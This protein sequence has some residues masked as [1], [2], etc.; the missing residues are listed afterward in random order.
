[1]ILALTLAGLPVSLPCAAQRDDEDRAVLSGH[2]WFDHIRKPV[3]L[4]QEQGH[5]LARRVFTALQTSRMRRDFVP[6]G[7][8]DYAPRLVFLSWRSRDG[9]LETRLGR[10]EGLAKAFRDVLRSVTK[11]RKH[12]PDKNLTA[13][14]I[15]IVQQSFVVSTF[16]VDTS[17]IVFPSVTGLAFSETSGFAFLP[18]ELVFNGFFQKQLLQPQLIAQRL[19]HREQW[20]DFG[21]WTRISSYRRPQ[22]VYLFETQAFYADANR[23]DTL[24]NG[25][26]LRE[27]VRATELLPAARGAGDFLCRAVETSGRITFPPMPWEVQ[28]EELGPANDGTSAPPS[29]PPARPPDMPVPERIAAALALLQLHH[30]T[31]TPVFAEK[32]EALLDPLVRTLVLYDR[33]GQALCL[34][35]ANGSGLGV[36]ALLAAVLATHAKTTGHDE[37]TEQIERIGRHLLLQMQP[38]GQFSATCILPS[39]APRPEPALPAAAFRAV[40]ALV[41]LYETTGNRSFVA[42][43]RRGTAFLI[44]RCIGPRIPIEKLPRDEWSVMALNRLY[45]YERHDTIVA[46]VERLALAIMAD[47]TLDS[48]LPD[49]VGSWREYPSAAAAA[50]MSQ[51]LAA[52][53]ELLH[54]TGREKAARRIAETVHAYLLFQMQTRYGDIE[55]F[56]L[57]RAQPFAGGFRNDCLGFA[58]SVGGQAEQILSLLAA[59]RLFEALK[60]DDELP[61]SARQ[62]E[63]L[64]HAR[65]MAMTFPR[66]LGRQ[67]TSPTDGTDRPPLTVQ[68]VPRVP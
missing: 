15:D 47:Q 52:A 16:N 56:Y 58:F 17:E 63:T 22:C 37:Y 32:A 33:G 40:D 62:T 53:G 59:R 31:T 61:L 38:D 57:D 20:E 3:S 60:L 66:L 48:P 23:V 27:T 64:D 42:G 24:F 12:R 68:P 8:V 67:T 54:D 34:Q 41:R 6:E 1:M 30:T 28:T 29:D 9:G 4:T 35:E 19:A 65:N 50:R 46:T 26:A 10:G 2:I 43:A 45:T 36:N 14:K 18:E 21:N 5:E 44:D 55:S 39:G 25:H 49:M 11:D 13:V 51:A 7:I